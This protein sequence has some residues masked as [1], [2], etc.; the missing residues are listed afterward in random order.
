[1]ENISS[2]AIRNQKLKIIIS[3]LTGSLGSG[4]FS[5][6]I[7]LMILRETGSASNFG[8]S[9]IVGPIVSL[10]LLPFTGSI[11]D[12]YNRKLIVIIAQ[13]SS[14]VAICLFLVANSMAWLPKLY[15]IYILLT[16]LAVS[17]LFLFTTYSAST[18]MMVPK[19]EVQK[20]MSMKQIV[21]TISMIGSPI[22]GATLY[23]FLSFEQFVIMEIASEII[24]L[25]IVLGIDFYLFKPDE[26][27]LSGEENSE[28]G[29]FAS[30]KKG[31]IFI[32]ENNTISFMI[33][34]AMFVNLTL[35]STNVGLPFIKVNVFHFNNYEYGISSVPFALGMLLSGI[36]LANRED[37]D[38]PIFNA[39]KLCFVLLFIILATGLVIL[40]KLS[41]LGNLIFVMAQAGVS[42][43]LVGHINT[44]IGVWNSKNIPPMMQGRVSNIL[45]TGCQLLMPIGTMFFGALFDYPIR[46][47]FIFIVASLIGIG[48]AFILPTLLRVQ[49]REL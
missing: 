31:L 41:H 6:G 48:V 43:V 23:G 13:L 39:W 25:L 16:I 49:I 10:L 11:V 44:P 24:T 17:D 40:F 22:L 26:E 14:I 4:I 34:F 45:S 32:R 12:K 46:P 7:G 29:I 8:F 20:I 42:G 1:M 28:E 5:F 36:I 47:D 33:V 2:L 18:I 30:F 37:F 15:L 9:Q 21:R 38:K 27:M 35:T 3:Q 19:E